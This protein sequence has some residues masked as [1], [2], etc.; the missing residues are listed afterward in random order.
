[1][2]YKV[3]KILE[4]DTPPAA[5]VTVKGWIKSARHSKM[6]SFIALSDGSCF[7]DLQLVCPSNLPNF[8]DTVQTLGTGCSII[9]TGK[10]VESQGKG[11]KYELLI[12]ELVCTG[13]VESDYPL[14]KKTTFF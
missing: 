10:I 13:K 9:A 14:Q 4:L 3:I 1:M 6:D 12:H 5:D 11:Q 8:F 7:T 2:N